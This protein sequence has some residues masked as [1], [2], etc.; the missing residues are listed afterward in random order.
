MAVRGFA[1]PADERARLAS[2]SEYDLLG[3]VALPDL[4]SVLDIA[5]ELL[6]VPNTVVN[7][8]GPEHQHQLAAV[9]FEPG[10]VARADSMCTISILEPEPV[11]VTDARLDPR[12]A[13]NPFVTGEID[14]IRFYAAAQLRAADGHV[15]GTLC[16]YDTQPRELTP[17]QREAL[18]KLSLLV[19][20]VLELHRHARML[21]DT[22]NALQATGRELQ[23]SNT[24]LK[25]FAAQV[26]HDLRNPLTGVLG[27]VAALADNPSVAGDEDAQHCVNRA[28]TS[29][30]RMWR[31]IEDVLAHAAAGG[32]P[33][34]GEVALHDLAAQAVD[35]LSV[36]V[37]LAGATVH[38][39]ALP[40]V[41]GDAA[42]LRV[43][44][45]NLVS[46]AVKFRSPD[47]PCEVF[48]RG[49]ETDT[50][51]VLR[52]ADNGIGIPAQDR[53]LVL[54]MF[55][56]LHDT[57]EGSGIGLATVQRIA[58]AHG[59]DLEITDTPG[60]GT[61]FTVALPRTEHI[62]AGVPALA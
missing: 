26:S 59:A 57:V 29:A 56:R 48:I 38:V 60:G 42:Q 7:I 4:L 36:Q 33:N 1:V 58:Q 32:Q 27:F 37:R 45:Q 51:W 23:R 2:L 9:G 21:H 28:L 5:A 19:M 31:M 20:D 62:A 41:R 54:E 18:D 11:V 6:G 15:L 24:A 25:H 34:A 44:L 35:D 52:V 40:V 10:V 14:D 47:R 43:L 39:G 22:V 46:N 61:T 16:A 12:F 55:T 8:I 30:T 13:D 3:G 49:G 17:R 53:G 50:H